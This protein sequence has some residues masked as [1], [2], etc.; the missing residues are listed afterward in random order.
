MIDLTDEELTK[1]YYE[2]NGLDPKRYY[3]ITTERIFTAMRA[4]PA[5]YRQKVIEQSITTMVEIGK[6]APDG[7]LANMLRR[8]G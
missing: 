2:A 5:A 4:V 3:P 6:C 7:D 1:I 8:M